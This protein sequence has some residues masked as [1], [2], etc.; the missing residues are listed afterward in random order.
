MKECPETVAAIQEYC[1]KEK[2]LIHQVRGHGHVV[3]YGAGM[4]GELVIR[5]LS[6]HG[7]KDRVL[8][9]AVSKTGDKKERDIVCGVPVYGIDEWETQREHILVIVATLPALHESM[10]RRAAELGFRFRKG[11]VKIWHV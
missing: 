8:G 3:I 10:G 4:V 1:D 7:Q 2:Q 6:M 5:Y 9:F 11:Q